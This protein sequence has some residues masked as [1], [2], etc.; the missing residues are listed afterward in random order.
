MTNYPNFTRRDFEF[1]ASTLLSVRDNTLGQ[2]R[3][4]ADAARVQW[5][6]T[7][8]RFASELGETNNGFKRER[9]LRACGVEQ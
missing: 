2:T 9:F 7:V 6:R 4:E 5:E 3:V 1:I 8:A